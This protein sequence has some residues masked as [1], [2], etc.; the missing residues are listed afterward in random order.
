[1]NI[2]QLVEE[3]N[4]WVAVQPVV[5][6]Y[7]VSEAGRLLGIT[8]A[9]VNRTIRYK[10]LPAVKFVSGS[11][12]DKGGGQTRIPHEDLVVWMADHRKARY[13]VLD[14]ERWLM[15][16]PVKERY[17]ALDVARILGVSSGQVYSKMRYNALRHE[18]VQPLGYACEYKVIPHDELM[19]YVDWAKSSKAGTPVGQVE[20]QP[21]DGY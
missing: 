9:Q 10:D 3:Q 5:D 15:V 8:E 18:T 11:K 19:R 20:I 7:T 13:A 4:A 21:Y 6:Y 2:A 17:V 1:M 12:R 16:I 14:G